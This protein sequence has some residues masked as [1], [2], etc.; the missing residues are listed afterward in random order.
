MH[1][2]LLTFVD[3]T[4]SFS[5]NSIRKLLDKSR[6]YTFILL[7]N[8]KA[9]DSALRSLKNARR[10]LDQTVPKGECLQFLLFLCDIPGVFGK[11]NLPLSLQILIVAR[12]CL[13]H[14]L[15]VRRQYI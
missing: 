11:L 9:P 14:E 10:V 6:V 15:S 1:T 2:S 12:I 8:K 5:V 4:G 7:V 3:C 13:S